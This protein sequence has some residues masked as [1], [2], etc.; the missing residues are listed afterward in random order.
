MG[1]PAKPPA[2]LMAISTRPV[3]ALAP[4]NSASMDDSSFMSQLIPIPPISSASA[5]SRC[6]RRPDITTFAPFLANNRAVETPKL[7]LPEAPTIT[8]VLPSRLMGNSCLSAAA[9]Y[10]P[11]TLWICLHV[12]KR[13]DLQPRFYLRVS[14]SPINGLQALKPPG[15]NP[16]W[17]DH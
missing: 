3:C 11:A 12:R 7:C 10:L 9:R 15:Q 17:F 13:M 2:L 14:T 8:A 5:S 16:P 4:A 1:P 6:C